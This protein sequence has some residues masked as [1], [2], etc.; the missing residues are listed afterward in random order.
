M[1]T[2]WMAVGMAWLALAAG[3]LAPALAAE[4][5][6]LAV[7]VLFDTSGSM[8]DAVSDAAGR[9]APKY[10]IA[11]RA[12]DAI[13]DRLQGFA[14]NAVDGR[15]RRVV[16]GLYVFDDYFILRFQGL[17]DGIKNLIYFSSLLDM[18]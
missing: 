15:P 6:D 16:A 14:T 8:A 1:R 7:A 10:V 18:W 17:T 4:P 9:P 13:A 5:A 2:S 11:G 12:L 3:A